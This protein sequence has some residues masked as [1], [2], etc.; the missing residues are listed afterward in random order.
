VVGD[1]MFRKMYKVN[2]D[3]YKAFVDGGVGV[4]ALI[5]PQSQETDPKQEMTKLSFREGG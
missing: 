2:E 1:G 4:R 5:V 3:T